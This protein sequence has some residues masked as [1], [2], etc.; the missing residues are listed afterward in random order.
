[1][2]YRSYN[3]RKTG[4]FTFIELLIAIF[5]SSVILIAIFNF[6]ISQNR[7]YSVQDQVT[8]IQQNLRAAINMMVKEIRMAGYDPSGNA[9][10]GILAASNDGIRFTMDLD[11]D[12]NTNVYNEDITY[13][14]YTENG[15]KKLGRMSP[16]NASMQP[17]AENVEALGFAYA[18]D[19]DG[20][21]LL[22]TDGSQ[23]I[24]AVKSGSTWFDLDTNDDGKIDANDLVNTGQDTGITANLS[25]IRAVRIWLLIGTSKKDDDFINKKTYI[26]GNQVITPSADSDTSNDHKRMRVLETYVKLR[27]LSLSTY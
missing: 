18:F 21:D 23:T 16:F 15:I 10:A 4:G 25:D 6:Y 19:S 27:N 12:G 9:G 13:G 14:I 5:M 3:E 20:D 22:D 24:W 8:E 1:M 17:L 2:S 11:M 7:S 26:V